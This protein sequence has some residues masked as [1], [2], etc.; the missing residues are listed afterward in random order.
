VGL[1]WSPPLVRLPTAEVV[2]SA[3]ETFSVTCRR[4]SGSLALMASLSS[5]VGG[6]G[7]GPVRSSAHPE[8]IAA[9]GEPLGAEVV[10]AAG[11]EVVAVVGNPSMQRWLPL[12]VGLSGASFRRDSCWCSVVHSCRNGARVSL[13]RECND[14]C[15]RAECNNICTQDFSLGS[16]VVCSD[17]WM[18][19]SST[20]T[21]AA[22]RWS[23]QAHGTGPG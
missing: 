13:V 11:A 14:I 18:V 5:P 21:P 6:R 2:A 3:G 4:T 12:L 10:V 19:A 15:L 16:Q 7:R 17:P 8:V 20:K 23:M 22:G 9:A 1:T